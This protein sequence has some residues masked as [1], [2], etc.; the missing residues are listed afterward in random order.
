MMVSLTRWLKYFL[1]IIIILILLILWQ[2][3]G[4][5]EYQIMVRIAREQTILWIGRVIKF[6]IW[7]KYTLCPKV[8][9]FHIYWINSAAVD[10]GVPFS[11]HS[12]YNLCRKASL[13]R[14]DAATAAKDKL[15]VSTPHFRENAEEA[16][17]T[18]FYGMK[19]LNDKHN[20]YWFKGGFIPLLY[21]TLHHVS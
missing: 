1:L 10:P 18:S 14:W 19:N 7:W 9:R 12:F 4:Q 16:G 15:P 5:P 3:K 8:P 2:P 17:S 13:I 11:R 6:K 21:N 20:E